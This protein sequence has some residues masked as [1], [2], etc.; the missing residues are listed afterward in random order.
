MEYHRVGC[1]HLG[2]FCCD[3]SGLRTRSSPLGDI[4]NS[5]PVYA[6]R[7]Q[8][9]YVGANDGMLHAFNANDGVERFAYVPG[10]INLSDLSTL[11]L[12]D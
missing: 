2:L 10:G 6:A 12:P 7:E 1:Q 3:V 8:T 4:V 5:S 9:I 11:S